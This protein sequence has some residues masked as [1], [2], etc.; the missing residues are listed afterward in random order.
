M[1]VLAHVSMKDAANCDK[2]CEWQ[3][4]GNQLNAERILRF[5]RLREKHVCFRALKTL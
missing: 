3:N 2:H 4:S 5:L 1:D